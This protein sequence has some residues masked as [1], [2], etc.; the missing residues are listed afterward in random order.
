MRMTWWYISSGKQRGPVDRDRSNTGRGDT[1][2]EMGYWMR[3]LAG[4]RG[5]GV[6]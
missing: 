6:G 5:Y 2:L 4:M 1:Y 3:A